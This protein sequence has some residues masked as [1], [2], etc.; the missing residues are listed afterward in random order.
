MNKEEFE[1]LKRVVKFVRGEDKELKNNDIKQ[2]EDWVNRADKGEI[3]CPQCGY[4]SPPK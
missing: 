4:F 2:V 1:A 3:V